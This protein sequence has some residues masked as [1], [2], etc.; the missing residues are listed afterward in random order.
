MQIET[1]KKKNPTPGAKTSAHAAKVRKPAKKAAIMKV[2]PPSNT[3]P[4]KAPVED[5]TN[6]MPNTTQEDVP[7][8]PDMTANST[9][10]TPSCVL[11]M[12]INPYERPIQFSDFEAQYGIVSS[13]VTVC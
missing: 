12:R 5:H 9:V 10:V 6:P 7:M 11:A 1:H 4:D 3:I 2:S 13:D 8:T